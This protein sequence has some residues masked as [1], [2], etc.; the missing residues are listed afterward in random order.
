[1]SASSPVAA[2][3]RQS[4]PRREGGARLAVCRTPA[5]RTTQNENRTPAL[6]AKLCVVFV[7]TSRYVACCASNLPM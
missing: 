2:R 7:P 5:G 4:P 1:M 3:I 6:K